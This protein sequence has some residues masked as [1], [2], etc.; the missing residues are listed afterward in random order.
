MIRARFPGAL[1]YLATARGKFSL[2]TLSAGLVAVDCALSNYFYITLTGNATL[3][4]PTN[5][6]VAGLLEA[7][8]LYF[9]VRQD[10]TGSRTLAFGTAYRFPGN[11]AP[12]L[13]TAPAATDYLAF[14]YNEID[15]RFDFQGSS[16]N[17]V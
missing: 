13:T 10:A 15:G 8:V 11:T 14:L 4:N 1:N 2:L 5:A 3:S 9:R 6:P 7:A 17:L 16:P 12:V